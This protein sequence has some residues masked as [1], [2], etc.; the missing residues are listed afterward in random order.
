MELGKNIKFFLATFLLKE[1]FEN[2]VIN[3][4]EKRSIQD[5]IEN[6]SEDEIM[7]EV[8]KSFKKIKIE[9]KR[10]SVESIKENATFYA[11]K[12]ERSRYGA[13]KNSRDFK[14]FSRTNSNNWRT[15]SGNRWRKSESNKRSS[16]R[17]QSRRPSSEFKSMKDLFEAMDKFMKK[18]QIL[19]EKQEKLS[20]L[21]DDKVVNA[22]F[23][24]TDFTEEDWSNERMN[25]Y[26]T[27]DISEVNEIVVDCGAPKSLIGEKYLNEYLKVQNIKYEQLDR[28]PCKQKFRFGPSQVYISTEK[29]K[30]PINLESESGSEM[31][32]VDS[33]VIQADVPFLLGL[34]TMKEWKALMDME[35]EQMVF[36]AFSASVKMKRNIGGHM[37]V[38]LQKIRWWSPS[39]TVLFMNAEKDVC[40]F[41]K[42]KKVH[43]NTNHKS[44]ENMIHAY[45]QANLLTDTVRKSIKKVCDNCLICQKYKKSQVKPKVA[46]P[47]VTDFNQV[48]TLDLKQFG[49]KYVLWAVD[50]FTRFIQGKALK[51]K[52]ADTYC[53]KCCS[54]Y[55]V[56]AFWIS[57]QR[58]LGRQWN[59]VPKQGFFGIDV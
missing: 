49:D 47:K 19:D 3:E 54:K 4:I 30:I 43:V 34:N 20:K 24:E 8:K 1:T 31:Q 55:L 29:I 25:I 38:P 9:G 32:Y 42:I 15:N 40:S 58:I 46:L 59:R 44:E 28:S 45:K 50:S 22:K 39:A 18:I 7:V 2:E 48:V 10:E 5:I 17:S 23:V 52:Q 14:D 53:A 26:F 35:I 21:I 56:F 11:Q 51:N 6:K 57:K 27:N 41:E 12:Y 36:R 16:S 37:T 13:W 33:Y